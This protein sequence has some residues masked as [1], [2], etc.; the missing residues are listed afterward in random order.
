MDERSVTRPAPQPTL[1]VVAGAHV[2]DQVAALLGIDEKAARRA[3][4][5]EPVEEVLAMASW[6]LSHEEEAG[7]DTEGI[8]TAWAEKRGRGAWRAEDPRA[9]GCGRC[10]GS[11][12]A[13]GPF[14]TTDEW[15]ED[16][17]GVECPACRGSGVSLKPLKMGFNGRKGR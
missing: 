4:L 13:P 17:E 10:H 6:A 7:F 3:F 1:R 16:R 12:W 15:G 8:L 11:G 5:G 2:C 9:E 14:T